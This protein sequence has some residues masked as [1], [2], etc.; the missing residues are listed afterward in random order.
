[1]DLLTLLIVVLIILWAVGA[2]AV[3]VAGNA[4]HLLLIVVI[5]LVIVRLLQ[6]RNL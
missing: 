4:V 3:P 1:M 2:L 6:G 5:V